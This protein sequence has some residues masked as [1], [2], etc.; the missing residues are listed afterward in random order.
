[1]ISDA[2]VVV[3][4][5]C[6]GLA[7]VCA[8]VLPEWTALAVAATGLLVAT[9]WRQGTGRRP[10]DRSRSRRAVGLAVSAVVAATV[11]WRAELDLAG[12]QQPLPAVVDGVAEL[13][14][15][16]EPTT[17]GTRV[18]LVVGGR[19]W[20]ALVPRQREWV[21]RGLRM[22]DRVRVRARP[23][24]LTG[25]PTGWVRS[26][27]LAGRLE[28]LRVERAR[29]TPAWFAVANGVLERLERGASSFSEP[30]RRLYLGL[31]VGDDRGQ[32]ELTRHRF[33]VA[34]LTHLL[35]VSGQNVAFLLAV[36]AP[37]FRRC[38]SRLRLAAGAGAVAA[39]VVLTRAEPSVLRA[40]TMAGLGLWAASVGRRAPGMR[41]VSLATVVLLIADP[42]LVHSVGFQLSLAAT[43]ALVLLSRPLQAWLPG[44]SWLRLPLSVT[45]AAQAGALPVM[46]TRFGTASVV[47]VPAN[48]LAEPAAGF[49][50]MSGLTAGLVA[51][52]V[53]VEPAALLQWP[54]GVL[55]WWIDAVARVASQLSVPR[56]ALWGWCLLAVVVALA[57]VVH[58]RKGAPAA[59]ALL[60]AVLV[61]L[62][63]PP[64]TILGE[65]QLGHG[66]ALLDRCGI[67]VLV[68]RDP[69]TPGDVLDALAARGIARV[70]A[71]VGEPSARDVPVELVE[72]L[73]ARVVERPPSCEESRAHPG[74]GLPSTRGPPAPS[75][76]A[77]LPP[78]AVAPAARLAPCRSR[79]LTTSR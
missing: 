62:C 40:A 29:G 65:L 6:A 13:G 50:M 32:S 74:P 33:R 60:V 76:A 5:L 64:G 35:A 67:R 22:G 18:E 15:D 68:V 17:Y 44:P 28:V 45:L 43:V 41:V 19:R 7:A 48:L 14:G 61:V 56:L 9:A 42:M 10:D 3:A 57:V 39:F 21:V 71:V 20:S 34:G 73:R 27:H 30:H 78:G 59:Y 8:S 51:G 69:A 26:R 37:L 53:R 55:L 4:A 79:W 52:L 11:L 70:G 75:A 47:A 54:T 24:P 66:V 38:G 12:L 25:A 1:M 46:A 16:P 63:R 72:Q 49:V 31:V 2:A 23:S 58:R 36:L 77:L